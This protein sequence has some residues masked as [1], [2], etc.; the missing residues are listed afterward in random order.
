MCNSWVIYR[1]INAVQV[2]V[3]AKWG[4]E[5]LNDCRAE[6]FFGRNEIVKKKVKV[7][8]NVVQNV[9]PGDWNA[10]SIASG[11]FSSLSI[12]HTTSTY[13]KQVENIQKQTWIFS[14][15]VFTH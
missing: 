12:Q 4:Q 7:A 6:T 14:S 3:R 8:Y 10:A 9:A 5:M 11:N 15:P 2:F 1:D 13:F